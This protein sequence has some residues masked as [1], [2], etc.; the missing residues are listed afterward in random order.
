LFDLNPNTE[1]PEEWSVDD[2]Y[3]WAI[4]KVGVD[5]ESA[6]ILKSR[7]VD[8]KTLLTL[9]KAELIQS[10]YNILGGSASRL[11]EAVIDL[12]DKMKVRK[13]NCFLF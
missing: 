9:T 13:G 6:S 3:Y 2:V 10:S 4:G 5:E 1:N 7:N 8:G 11:T 12:N